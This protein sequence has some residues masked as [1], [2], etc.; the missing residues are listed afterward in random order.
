[1]SD[2]DTTIEY[3]KDLILYQYINKP[4][5]TETIKLLAKQAMVDLLP[6]A[7]NDAFD[8][9]TAIG[10]QLDVLGEYIGFDRIIQSQVE[11]DY[12]T[13]QNQDSETTLTMGL[14]DYN[15][16][17][18][19]STFSFYSYV[20]A[21]GISSS[22]SDDEYRILLKLKLHTN[23][24]Q[25]SLYEI[26]TILF[27]YFS[28]QIILFDQFDMTISYFVK[29]SISRIISIAYQEDLLPKP[30]GVQISGVFAVEDPLIVWGIKSQ[31]RGNTGIGG[32]IDYNAYCYYLFDYVDL[33]DITDNSIGVANTYVGS[34][35]T[36][37]NYV[38]Y[39]PTCEFYLKQGSNVA[40]NVYA[41]LSM[42]DAND[43]PVSSVTSDSTGVAV[44]SGV[45]V[46]PGWVTFTFDTQVNL[47]PN[48][49]YALLLYSTTADNVETHSKY[50]GVGYHFPYN[51]G[52]SGW[53]F[54]DYY[55][56]VSRSKLNVTDTIDD[57]VFLNYEDKI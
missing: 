20:N 10:S 37:P 3:Y 11:R 28:N 9:D 48:T 41:V 22:L 38:C 33:V 29:D 12:F 16:L 14:T 15:N 44:S 32:F 46:S 35:I 7:V 39:I 21:L 1:M 27:E 54:I 57:E 8:I 40:G 2:L 17:T 52:L 13:F 30:M 34:I 45:P 53:A 4:K 47:L 6:I 51:A 31:A 19:N 36:T 18:L 26:A 23:S 42:V 25:N 43:T 56:I 24:T 5:A 49:K 55:V 50:L